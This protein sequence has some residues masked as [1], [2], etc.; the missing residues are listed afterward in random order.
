MVPTG[1]LSPVTPQ[2]LQPRAQLSCPDSAA[3]AATTILHCMQSLVS[4]LSA[5]DR[6]AHVNVRSN[7]I[8]ILYTGKICF[9]NLILN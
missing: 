1:R 6:V 7:Q 3:A 9:L 5:V 8:E 2:P 4:L